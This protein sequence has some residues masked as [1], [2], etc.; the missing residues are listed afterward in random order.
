MKKIDDT[1]FD[2]LYTEVISDVLDSIGIKNNLMDP[3]IKALYP[4]ARVVGRAATMLIADI[5]HEPTDEPYTGYIDFVDGLTAGEIIIIK[6]TDSAA[7]L[8]E[9]LATAAKVRGSVGTIVDGY[10]RDTRMLLEMKWPSFSRGNWS[11]DMTARC[12]VYR[13]NVPIICGGVYV[14][15]GDVVFADSGGIVVIPPEK[16]DTV[17]EQAKYKVKKEDTVR[18]EL[19]RGDKLSDVWKRHHTL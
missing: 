15:P 1:M 19:A 6:G 17:I 8:G 13:C 11:L 7:I 4:E 5:Y 10:H 3:C 14:K 16:L 2:G 18:Q 12:T 9:L